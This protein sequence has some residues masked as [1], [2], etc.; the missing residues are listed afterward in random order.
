MI[1]LQ[2]MN[3][4]II[5]TIAIVVIIT[6]SIYIFFVNKSN[7]QEPLKANEITKENFDSYCKKCREENP[8]CFSCCDVTFPDGET[9]ICQ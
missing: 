5:L 8:Y 2:S 6:L 7:N 1:C 4:K 3:K 9:L